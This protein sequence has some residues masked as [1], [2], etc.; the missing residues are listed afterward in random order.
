MTVSHKL[1][2]ILSGHDVSN[3]RTDVQTDRRT[4]ERHTIIRPKF[5]FGRIKMG[6]LEICSSVSGPNFLLVKKSLH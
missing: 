6:T 2:K 5:H 3:G 4:D 1:F